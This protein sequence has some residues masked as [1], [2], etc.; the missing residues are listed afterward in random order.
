MT[1]ATADAP[2][3]PMP[4]LLRCRSDAISL[5]LLLA[6]GMYLHLATGEVY[7]ATGAGRILK[8]V[9]VTVAVAG[10]VLGYRFRALGDHF[11]YH[12]SILAFR[13]SRVRTPSCEFPAALV[14][15]VELEIA[16][17]P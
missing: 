17:L 9:A 4:G 1:A 14:A 5:A 15:A 2:G 11:V 3:R 10:I 12:L 13:D 7:G 16:A 6:C 8:V